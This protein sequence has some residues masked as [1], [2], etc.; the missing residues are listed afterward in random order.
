MVIYNDFVCTK[1]NPRSLY[2]LCDEITFS[3]PVADSYPPRILA[4]EANKQREY[5]DAFPPVL[6]N[7]LHLEN[8][9]IH[10][11]LETSWAQ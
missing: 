7:N 5:C 2:I 1:C 3:K 4:T 6:E 8:C 10:A 9:D 11:C